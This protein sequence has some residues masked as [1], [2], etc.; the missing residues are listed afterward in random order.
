MIDNVVFL[1][2]MLHFAS[3]SQILAELCWFGNLLSS[4]RSV[5]TALLDSAFLTCS[6]ILT[7]KQTVRQKHTYMYIYI[8]IFFGAQFVASKITP[9][10]TH[11]RAGQHGATTRL[12]PSVYDSM[13][14]KKCWATNTNNG[15]S[16]LLFSMSP[17][18]AM[19]N[20]FLWETLR[21]SLPK[22][23][24]GLI[25]EKDAESK[26][27]SSSCCGSSCFSD[28]GCAG[29]ACFCWW[30]WWWLWMVLCFCLLFFPAVNE[31][32][33]QKEVYVG[34]GRI[35]SHHNTICF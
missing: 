14:T 23:N 21:V 6:R 28:C 22:D 5:G 12:G 33:T 20:E 35:S 2:S 1:E 24:K 3:S 30:S 34:K 25:V 7:A 8:Y 27:S 17:Q 15:Y 26:P 16:L 29:V 31:F 13:V 32:R 11:A 19:R 18:H 4:T 10:Q 9:Q